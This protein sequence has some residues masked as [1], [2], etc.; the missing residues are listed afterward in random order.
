MPS[1]LFS[2]RTCYSPDRGSNAKRPKCA[3]ATANAITIC[4]HLLALMEHLGIQTF[5][6]PSVR[7]AV[8]GAHAVG[9]R[10]AIVYRRSHKR[11]WRRTVW[12]GAELSHAMAQRLCQRRQ[13]V[14]LPWQ[15]S[16]LVSPCRRRS[17]RES[18]CWWLGTSGQASVSTFLFIDCE[19]LAAQ[20][21]R[22][23][24]VTSS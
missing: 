24:L 22:R 12:G 19:V 4:P 20:Y 16:P 17:G 15:R 3:C 21:G 1:I 2:K 8:R 9:L 10:E 5:T 13:Q 18:I 11:T 23:R 6:L 7:P 14:M